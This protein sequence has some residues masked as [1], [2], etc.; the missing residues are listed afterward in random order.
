MKSVGF[1]IEG[2][3]GIDRLTKREVDL[4]PLAPRMVRVAIHAVSLNFRDL[5]MVRGQYNARQPLPLVPCSDGAGE[6]VAVGGEVRRF[7]V[8]DRVTTCFFQA[9]PAGA[10]TKDSIASTLGGPL[11]GTLRTVG[12]FTEDGLV[13]TPAH[14]DDEEASTLP[15]A[16]LT[17]WN[18]LVEQGGVKAGQVV[19][20][21]GTG[22]VSLASVQIARMIGAQVILTSR[23]SEKLERAR[24]FGLLGTVDTSVHAEWSKAVRALTPGGAGVDHV[25]EVGGAGTLAHA[26]RS[27]KPG[28]TASIIGVLTGAATEMQLTPVLM[29]N[30]RLQGILVGTREMHVRM[31]AAYAG[32]T[33]RPVIAARFSFD[34]TPRAFEAMAH[35]TQYGK[36]VIR[37][38][39]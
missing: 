3:F 39:S 36:I 20:V 8:G 27:L 15:C 7:R 21:Q 17:A 28:G 14:L 5:M 35:G 6:V 33:L 12:D 38:A 2:A 37:V 10:P 25:V 32:A 31:N 9:Y 24:T 11:P 22:G 4:G 23:S 18:A 26:I 19:L 1:P 34:D 16:A 29:Q 13:P 30:L